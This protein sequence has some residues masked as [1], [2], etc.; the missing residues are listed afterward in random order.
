MLV[1]AG[2][3][4][5]GNDAGNDHHVGEDEGEDDGE[6]VGENVGEDDGEDVDVRPTCQRE[7]NP[8]SSC[9]VPPLSEQHQ[10]LS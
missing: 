1:L 7:D 8:H 10:I 6:D 5:A 3:Q 2:G 9:Q 4:I